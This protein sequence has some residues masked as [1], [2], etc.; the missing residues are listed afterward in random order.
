MVDYKKWDK[1]DYGSSDE[2][3][4]QDENEPRVTRFDQGQKVTFGGGNEDIV[5]E[6]SSGGK[7]IVGSIKS[8]NISNS[9]FGITTN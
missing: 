2:E 3:S 5:I 4:M 8:S 9:S 7:E 1:L 6:P